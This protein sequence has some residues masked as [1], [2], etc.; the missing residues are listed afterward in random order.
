[1]L[2]DVQAILRDPTAMARLDQDSQ[3]L[4]LAEA[5]HVRGWSSLHMIM[6][7]GVCVLTYATL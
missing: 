2:N 7:V 5:A 3:L 4:A 1:M 6:S